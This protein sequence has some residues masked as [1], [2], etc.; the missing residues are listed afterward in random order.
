MTDARFRFSKKLAV[1]APNANTRVTTETQVLTSRQEGIPGA[2][3]G[4]FYDGVC[5]PCWYSAEN[6][7]NAPFCVHFWTRRLNAR[8]P[9]LFPFYLSIQ[10][11]NCQKYVP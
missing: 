7:A 8:L 2:F 4:G 5:I 1:D 10:I 9:R 3:Y 6:S 11:L